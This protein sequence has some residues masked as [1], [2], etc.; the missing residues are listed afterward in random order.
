M[1]RRRDGLPRI[2]LF[3]VGGGTLDGV[4][5]RIIANRTPTRGPSSSTPADGYIS[6]ESREPPPCSKPAGGAI[7]RSPKRAPISRGCATVRKH[8]VGYNVQLA[9]E[10]GHTNSISTWQ[11]SLRSWPIGRPVEVVK[12]QIGG[13]TF[14]QDTAGAR[15]E[16]RHP[17]FDRLRDP[18]RPRAWFGRIPSTRVWQRNCE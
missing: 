11:W 1:S 15:R 6:G 2:V 14:Q 10:A 18:Q 7:R 3:D 17:L 5:F 9:S 16:H 4:S 13:V 8:L 12:L